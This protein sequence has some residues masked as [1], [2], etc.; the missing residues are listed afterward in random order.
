MKS[1]LENVHIV[2]FANACN[3]NPWF[4][5][6]FPWTKDFVP[7][8]LKQIPAQVWIK[9][10]SLSQKYWRPKIIF[11]IASTIWTLICINFAYNKTTFVE[12]LVVMGEF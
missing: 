4:L 11:A 8:T 6:L 3:L 1:C 10:H 12:L 9:I 2:R 5:K 7:S